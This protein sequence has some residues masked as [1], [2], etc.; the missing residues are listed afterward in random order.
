MQ[1]CLNG[2]PQLRAG[3]DHPKY[4][5]QAGS[6]LGSVLVPE[7]PK[8]PQSPGSW[9]LC[10][11]QTR[12]QRLRNHRSQDWQ[13]P[14]RASHTLLFPTE[15]A[16]TCSGPVPPSPGQMFR[17]G[18][19]SAAAGPERAPRPGCCRQRLAADY[20]AH[21]LSLPSSSA[22]QCS[23]FSRPPRLLPGPKYGADRA[24]CCT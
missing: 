4:L 18:R 15:A 1:G 13:L 17:A 16:R 10:V 19:S 23:R 24:S 20:R 7:V 9:W 6:S 21:I 5:E 2:V 12:A 3:P 11:Q 14:P 22:R 8:C